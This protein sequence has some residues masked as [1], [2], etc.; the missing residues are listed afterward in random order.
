MEDFLGTAF[1]KSVF[2]IFDGRPNQA[3]IIVVILTTLGLGVWVM[4]ADNPDDRTYGV[5]AIIFVFLV[6]LSRIVRILSQGKLLSISEDE[7][8]AGE[9]E[10]PASPEASD[11]PPPAVGL[12]PGVASPSLQ[13]VKARTVKIS[14]SGMNTVDNLES[15]WIG[16]LFFI[17]GYLVAYSVMISGFLSHSKSVFPGW[18]PNSLEHFLDRL[19]NPLFQFF[20]ALPAAVASFLPVSVLLL[21]LLGLGLK[22]RPVLIK[23]LIA[24]SSFL[25]AV[26]GFSYFQY[27]LLLWF[28]L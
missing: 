11:F 24:V 27:G 19:A 25:L 22:N 3:F 4:T 13:P 12:Q 21:V 5:I 20:F 1:V 6:T 26:L 23:G 18:D 10:F 7:V 17:V 14:F 8:A 16:G 9:E 2:K 28:N 15:L